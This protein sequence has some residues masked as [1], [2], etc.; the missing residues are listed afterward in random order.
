MGR[1]WSGTILFGVDLGEDGLR[2]PYDER[3]DDEDGDVDPGDLSDFLAARAGLVSP[4]ASL[5]DEINYGPHQAF[6]DWKLSHPEFERAADE[7][8]E[9]K[10]K[11]ED[12]SPVDLDSYGA[13]DYSCWVLYLKGTK[14]YAYQ[15][16]ETVDLDALR[17]AAAPSKV[18]LAQQFCKA[19]GL[20]AFDD[21]KW[22]VTAY[23][24]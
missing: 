1:T 10:R 6:L 21:P 8:Y 20:P 19:N 18:A 23:S 13:S 17:A 4:Y 12:A 5:P 16:I 24:D 9:A 11:L 7:F 22:L 2:P 15:T 14:E 3:E